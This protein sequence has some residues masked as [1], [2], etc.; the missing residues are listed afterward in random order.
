MQAVSPT[1]R[2]PG[3]GLIHFGG[4]WCL[5]RRV[6]EVRYRPRLC[7][8]C[9]L[10]PMDTGRWGSVDWACGDA[11]PSGRTLRWEWMRRWF[12]TFLAWFGGGK[13]ATGKPAK[14]MAGHAK[15]PEES[16]PSRS[17]VPRPKP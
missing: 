14:P 1:T 12:P 15:R 9:H 8:A 10:R 7:P 16:T 3:C 11:Y 17:L 5:E 13:R 4:L 2:C 6:R